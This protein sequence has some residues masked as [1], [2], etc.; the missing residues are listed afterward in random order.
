MISGSGRSA[1]EGNGNPL[2][3]SWLETPTDGEVWQAMVHGVARVTHNL[4]T[5]PPCVED[6]YMLGAKGCKD[7]HSSSLQA[8]HFLVG[9]KYKTYT[10]C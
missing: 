5:K 8:S 9:W 7:E 4:A 1:G 3:Y 10:K 6:P 2:H